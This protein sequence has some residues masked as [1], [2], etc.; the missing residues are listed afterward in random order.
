MSFNIQEWRKQCGWSVTEAGRRLGLHRNTVAKYE[1][2]EIATP[3]TV[4]LACKALAA[5]ISASLTAAEKILLHENPDNAVREALEKLLKNPRNVA[6][7]HHDGPVFY[8]TNQAGRVV[9]L[10]DTTLG[11]VWSELSRV[12]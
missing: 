10:S 1:A 9:E 5:G 11:A 3:R 2:G 7:V 6:G 12:K 4:E 8:V